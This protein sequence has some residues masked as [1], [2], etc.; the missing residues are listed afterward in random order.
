MKKLF[1]YIIRNS[2]FLTAAA[3][4]FL[5]SLLIFVYTEYSYQ[6]IDTGSIWVREF[7]G[8]FYLWLGFICVIFLLFI[9]LSKFG[10][11][12]LGNA[13][14]QFSRLSWTAMLYSAGMGA[15][16]LLRAVQEPVYMFLNPPIKTGNSPETIALEYTFYHWGFTAWGFYGVFALLTAYSL[17]VRKNTI[18]LGSSLPQLQKVKLLP[19]GINLLTI[20]T[21]VFGLVAAVALGTTQIEGGISHLISSKAGNLELTLFLIFVICL[22]AFVSAWAGVE[23][24]IRRISNWNIYITIFILVLVFVQSDISGVMNDF[25]SSLFYYVKDFIP[26]SL[27]LGKY[28]P[29]QLFLTEWTYYYWAF[30]LAWAPFTGIFIARISKG[31]TIRETVLG[32]LLIPSLGSF[33]WFSVFG[34]ASFDLIDQWETY[35]G[36]FANVFTSIFR[37]FEAFPFSGFTNL[38]IIVLL[39]GFLVT[40]IDSAIYVLSMFSDT[41]NENPGKK[42][43]FLWAL[44]VFIFSEAI[45]ILGNIKPDSDVLSAMQKLLIIS[46]LPFGIFTGAMILLLLK[47][48]MASQK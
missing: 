14:P 25:L 28:N 2:L 1:P 38:I 13:P 19:E 4:L 36:E 48:L 12:R 16:I 11:I 15:G 41:N 6:L 32:L 23:N 46:S 31:R 39:V 27:A 9:A 43:R 3:I 5:F 8:K 18:A 7:F 44:V 29:G 21:T 30:W 35:N 20:L 34:S 33:F 24:G 22:L 37:F 40:S 47:D 45:I 42:S 17:F 10:N 26:M